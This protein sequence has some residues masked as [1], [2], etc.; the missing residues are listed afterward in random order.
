MAMNEIVFV[1]SQ[2]KS[3][4]ELILPFGVLGG[5]LRFYFV[6]QW[7][8][9]ICSS[10]TPSQPLIVLFLRGMTRAAG[11]THCV[12]KSLMVLHPIPAFTRTHK[13]FRFKERTQ[14]IYVPSGTFPGRKIGMLEK[15][16]KENPCPIEYCFGT[17]LYFVAI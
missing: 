3:P 12:C 10:P 17:L 16:R 15:N 9:L 1:V 2:T 14:R 5:I 4:M 13:I 8:I 11:G 6:F 7:I